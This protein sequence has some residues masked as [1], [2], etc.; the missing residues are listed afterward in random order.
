MEWT[1]VNYEKL[2]NTVEQ[3]ILFLSNDKTKSDCERHNLYRKESNGEKI[4]PEER[5]RIDE[6][7]EYE[8]GILN[9]IYHIEQLKNNVVGALDKLKEH[10][11]QI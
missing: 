3:K 1:P 6:M 2:F 4:T 7:C 5:K 8:D 9:E 11:G 10:I